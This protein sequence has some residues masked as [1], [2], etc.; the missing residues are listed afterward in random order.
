ME[1]YAKTL[2]RISTIQHSL[3]MDENYGKMVSTALVDIYNLP[4]AYRIR[5]SYCCSEFF[6]ALEFMHFQHREGNIPRE[7]WQRW[8]DTTRFWMT[9][10]GHRQW[11]QSSPTL[12]T[13]AFSRFVEECTSEGYTVPNPQAWSDLLTKPM[14]AEDVPTTWRLTEIA[15]DK[16]RY[17]C[18]G[19]GIR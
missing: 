13:P 1:T 5:F 19:S 4:P 6:G 12:F 7:L 16:R 17:Q 8:A 11:W 10:K 18:P 9:F 3:A 2:E 15:G 14:I